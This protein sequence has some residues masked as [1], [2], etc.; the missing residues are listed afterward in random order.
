MLPTRL[1]TAFGRT[2]ASWLQPL[3]ITALTLL[4]LLPLVMAQAEGPTEPEIGRADPREGYER[5][6]FETRTLRISTTP[7]AR[8]DL[9]ALAAAPPLGLPPLAE[10]PAAAEIALGRRLFFDR[11][12]SANETL[13]CGMCHVPE[14]AFTQNELATSVGIEGAF[15]RRNAPA[16]YNVAYRQRLFHDGRETQLTEQIFSPLLAAN[17]MGNASREAVISR[18]AALPGYLAE[19]ER[20]YP[21][22]LDEAS[23]GQALAAYQRALLSADSPFDRWFYAGQTGAMSEQAKAGFFL[24]VEAGCNGCHGFSTDHAHFTDDDLHRTGIEWASRAREA[25]PPDRI[26]VAPGV[27][28]PLTVSVPAPARADFGLEEVTGQ[29]SDRFRYRTPTLRNVA[30]TAPYMHDGSLATLAAVVAFYNS[31]SGEDPERDS[32]L[33]PLGLNPADQQALVA[34]LESLTGANVGALA[35]DARSVPIG[36]RLSAEEETDDD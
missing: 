1:L 21:D 22:G 19:F 36:E 13:S 9:A 8:L 2:P 11:R 12:L 32:R 16:L 31:G 5:T 24:F 27:V 33:Q 7:G 18:I 3:R 17:E 26:Q 34:F 14:Q 20:I 35:A 4:P 30:L 10:V 15:V 25:S 29:P 28:I 6:S 23:L